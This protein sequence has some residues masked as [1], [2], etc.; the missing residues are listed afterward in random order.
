M[1]SRRPGA[2]RR[3]HATETME[4]QENRSEQMYRPLGDRPGS[5]EPAQMAHKR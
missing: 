1:G 2:R 5:A 3:V 4:S